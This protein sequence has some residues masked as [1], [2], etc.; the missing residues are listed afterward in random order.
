MDLTEPVSPAYSP[1]D[2]TV[3]PDVPVKTAVAPK[4]VTKARRTGLAPHNAAKLIKAKKS[5]AAV[6]KEFTPKKKKVFEEPKPI[7]KKLKLMAPITA[8]KSKKPKPKAAF[9]A[10]ASKT[11]EVIQSKKPASK[12]NPTA[13]VSKVE[14]RSKSRSLYH[15]RSKAERAL[16]DVYEYLSQKS[17]AQ[18]AN[19]AATKPAIGQLTP[20]KIRLAEKNLKR[21]EKR[22]LEARTS[23]QTAMRETDM[24]NCDVVVASERLR[25]A[26][27][28]DES[29]Y[30]SA[31]DVVMGDGFL[32][33]KEHIL[34][35]KLPGLS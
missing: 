12:L 11:K 27:M 14:K 5:K 26:K 34:A 21:A 3:I 30:Q 17:S 28:S 9:T 33:F 7:S 1:S 15:K 29:T 18:E 20:D 25:V 19:K 13:E 35:L 2:S 22:A 10:E 32:N 24:A 4:T 16:E 23:M 8:S 31:G 6:S